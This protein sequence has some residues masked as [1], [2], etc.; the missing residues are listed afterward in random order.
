MLSSSSPAARG[1][2]KKAQRLPLKQGI[3]FLTATGEEGLGGPA[4]GPDL[5]R[6]PPAESR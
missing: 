5:V 3:P 6:A 1:Q 2:H 4:P